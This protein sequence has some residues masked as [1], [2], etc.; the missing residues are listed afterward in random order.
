[1]SILAGSAFVKVSKRLCNFDQNRPISFVDRILTKFFDF[2]RLSVYFETKCFAPADYIRSRLGKT[3]A[4]THA[5]R[6]RP[7]F[8]VYLGGVANVCLFTKVT[9][10]V[11][12]FLR[13]APNL[14]GFPRV[15]WL[16]HYWFRMSYARGKSRISFLNQ[17]LMSLFSNEI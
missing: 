6:Q 14:L 12:G 17:R 2:C 3:S 16:R 7:H 9:S 4:E 1:M 13:L 10:S 8:H 5:Q 11:W 15:Q